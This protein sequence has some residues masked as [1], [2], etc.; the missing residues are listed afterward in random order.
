[1][2]CPKCGTPCEDQSQLCATCGNP[3][4]CEPI[5]FAPPKKGSHIPP[6]II[7]AVMLCIGLVCF[8]LFPKGRENTVP[9]PSTERDPFEYSRGTLQFRQ[10]YYTGGA[11][12]TVPDAIDNMPVLRLGESCFLDCDTLEEIILPQS[13]IEIDDSAFADCDALRGIYIPETVFRIGSRAFAD[14]E[15]LEA[16]YI[17]STIQTIESDA[18]MGS[19]GLQFILYDGTLKQWRSLFPGELP[20]SVTL[21][22]TDGAYRQGPTRP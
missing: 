12:L 15:R 18:F 10:E 20:G 5:I 9:D 14:C 7:M 11:S 6:V 4:S 16:V 19:D 21:Y 13:L 2:F 3:L 17:N 1:M 22:C 8:F